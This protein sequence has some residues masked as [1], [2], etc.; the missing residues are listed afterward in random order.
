MKRCSTYQATLSEGRAAGWAH[1]LADSA[2]Q[3]ALAPPGPQTLRTGR[4]LRALHSRR[5][6][7]PYFSRDPR[8]E[9]AGFRKL[10]GMA[11]RRPGSTPVA[12][13]RTGLYALLRV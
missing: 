2:C 5:R 4:R 6:K 13:R 8:S 12:A 11:G 1:G 7:R 9:A 10:A 3:E